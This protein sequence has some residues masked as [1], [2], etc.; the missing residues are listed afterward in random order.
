[1]YAIGHPTRLRLSFGGDR[2]LDQEGA[3]AEQCDADSAA[4]GMVRLVLVFIPSVPPS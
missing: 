4:P 1:M 3:V 2:Q